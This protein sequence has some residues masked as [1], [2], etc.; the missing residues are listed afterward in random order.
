MI[1]RWRP[2]LI[3]EPLAMLGLGGSAL[4]HEHVTDSVQIEGVKWLVVYCCCPW[5]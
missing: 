4:C 5:V 1:P 3:A 2:P